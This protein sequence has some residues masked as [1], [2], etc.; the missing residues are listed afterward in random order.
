V[1]RQG[2]LVACCL[3]LPVAAMGDPVPEG[4]LEAMPTTP[5][6]AA[7]P[8]LT[9]YRTG[10]EKSFG[11]V[12]GSVTFTQGCTQSSIGLGIAFDGDNLWFSCSS[13]SPDLFRA[14]PFTGV[15]DATYN[16]AGGLGAIAYDCTDNSI[17]AGWGGGDANGNIRRIGLDAN[18]DVIG[19]A[20][21]FAVGGH[22][23]T[24][25]LDDGIAI[26]VTTDP[27]TI[28]ISSDCS[29]IVHRYL[30]DGTHVDV[31]DDSPWTGGAQCYNSGLALGGDDLYQSANGCNHLFIHDIAP[32]PMVG[33]NSVDFTTI[34]PSDPNFRDEGLACDDSTFPVDVMWSI[35][36]YEPKRA[37]AFE[38]PDQTCQTCAAPIDPCDLPTPASVGAALRVRDHGSPNAPNVWATLDW[39]LDEGGPRT[40]GMA[41]GEEHYHILRGK[42][43][44]G[45]PPTLVRVS[46]TEPWLGVNYLDLTRRAVERPQVYGYVI[47]AADACET[48]S[49]DGPPSL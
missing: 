21:L 44:M 48:E 5:P 31:L 29:T 39:S 15:V 27:R 43:Q 32:W 41:R 19:S 42:L 16:I 10:L 1:I 26:D 9:Q 12:V 22:P 2:L 6:E 37:H 13:Q 40:L 30:Y 20:I 3:V 33:P 35:D 24:C 25:S 8:G 47:K 11:D 23:M 38:V 36:A 49:L 45:N 4:T 18:Q 46:N 34:V 7:V 28:Y 17:V 14:D